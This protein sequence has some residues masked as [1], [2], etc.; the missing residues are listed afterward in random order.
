M[1]FFGVKIFLVE[2]G[3]VSDGV[4]EAVPFFCGGKMSAVRMLY[5]A[6]EDIYKIFHLFNDFLFLESENFSIRPPKLVAFRYSCF[7]CN[8]FARI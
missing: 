1:K 5:P 3:E 7:C 8:S 2:G 4:R 6:F